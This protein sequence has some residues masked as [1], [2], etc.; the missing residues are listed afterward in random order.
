MSNRAFALLLVAYLVLRALPVLACADVFGFGEELAKSAA[1]KALL[2]GVPAPWP[3]LAYVPHEGGGFAVSHLEALL[4]LVLGESVLAVKIAALLLGTALLAAL[5]QLAREHFPAGTAW[6]AGLAVLFAPAPFVR[7]SLLAL[8]TH[9]EALLFVTLVLLFALRVLARER[10]RPRDLVLLGLSAG[11][12]LYFSLQLAPVLAA[13]VIALLVRRRGRLDAYETATAFAAFA[14]GALPLLAMFLQVGRDALIVRGEAV[15]GEGIGLAASA[16][17]LVAPILT[18]RDPLTWAHALLFAAAI[19]AGVRWREP[20]PRLVALYLGLYALAYVASGLA[21]EYDAAKPAAWF[22]LLRLAPPWLFLTLLA[23]AGCAHLWQQGGRG[24]AVAGAAVAAAVIAGGIDLGRLV[25]GG[26]ASAPVANLRHLA[27]TKGYA[28]AEYFDKLLPRL[29]SEAVE[30][31]RSLMV[32]RDDPRH[33]APAVAQ[34]LFER[35]RADDAV[36]IGLARQAF[37]PHWLDA[38][39]GMGRFLHTDWNYDVPGAFA[40]IDALPAET[41]GP[42]GEALGRA[43]LGPRFRADR[44]DEQLAVA[45]PDTHRAAWLRGM[46]WRIHQTFRYRPDLAEAYLAAQPA[47]VRTHLAQGWR[48]AREIDALP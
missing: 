47:E 38:L 7:F 15:P 2:D 14:A 29:S 33:L 6:F 9:Y 40:R 11:F 16:A 10:G 8:G 3:A 19:V 4:F 5:L 31:V 46:G 21:L 44:F 13:V 12:G 24:R 30:N 45:V 32:L 20:G 42:L 27:R 18:A 35:I 43:G 23:C 1:A 25:G 28:Y 22:F 36:A 26:H 48:T 34:S 39:R 17:G 41:H 37:G